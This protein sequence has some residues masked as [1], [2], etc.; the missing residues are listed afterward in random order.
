MTEYLRCNPFIVLLG[1]VMCGMGFYSITNCGWGASATFI[2]IGIIIY[3]VLIYGVKKAAHLIRYYKYHFAWIFLVSCGLGVATMLLHAPTMVEDVVSNKTQVVSGEVVEA[4][5]GS[6]SAELIVRIDKLADAKGVVKA[7]PTNL[8]VAISSHKFFPKRTRLTFIHDLCALGLN[9][10][11]QYDPSESYLRSRGIT[12]RQWLGERDVIIADMSKCKQSSIESLCEKIEISIDKC[13]LRHNTANFIKAITLGDKTSMM[14]SDIQRFR[15]SGLSH[16]LAISGL[17]VG[18]LS[19]FVGMLLSPLAFVLST[20]VRWMMVIIII[21]IYTALTGFQTA[22]VRASI[23]ISFCIGGYVVQRHNSSVNAIMAAAFF[24]LICDPLQL[25]S[26]GFQLSFVAAG[27]LILSGGVNPIN[28]HTHPWIWKLSSVLITSVT[29]MSSTLILGA[30]HFHTLPLSSLLPNLVGV[31]IMPFYFGLSL[32]Y[33]TL[34]SFGAD[35]GIM[36]ILL[37]SGYDFLNY[38]ADYGAKST[39]VFSGVWIHWIVVILSLT[40]VVSLLIWMR[41][42]RRVLLWLTVGN[43]MCAVMTTALLPVWRPSDGFIVQQGRFDKLMTYVDGTSQVFM[44]KAGSIGV[45]KL[46]DK[47]VGWVLTN[48][49]YLPECQYLLLGGGFNGELNSNIKGKI[50]LLSS[51]DGA[52]RKKIKSWCDSHNLACHDISTDGAL[53]VLESESDR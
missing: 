33:E 30:Y 11:L 8:K 25:I 18:I 6:E 9:P 35:I 21:W 15:L 44:P 31:W 5:Q 48:S 46:C 28:R 34:I 50:V 53:K 49:I 36:R 43:C 4:Y 52:A 16:L 38:M 22:A 45:C 42:R 27:M 20:S 12:C 39:F 10:N 37:D 41:T 14:P 13:L 24:I 51:L 19:L 23:M 40:S 7:K 26:P 29:A 2:F 1:G 3:V 17:H 47:K 32:I